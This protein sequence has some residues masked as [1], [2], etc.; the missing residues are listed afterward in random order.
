MAIR[1]QIQDL[2]SRLA[3]EWVTAM[4]EYV[5]EKKTETARLTDEFTKRIVDDS[6]RE[7]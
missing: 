2:E 4:A 6:K 3:A 1:V 7:E 5:D